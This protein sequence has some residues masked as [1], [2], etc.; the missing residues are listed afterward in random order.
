MKKLL[1]F[2]ARAIDGGIEKI[3]T[4]LCS[5]TGVESEMKHNSNRIELSEFLT[6][7][8]LK[9]KKVV[10]SCINEKQLECAELY[11][12]TGLNSLVRN[13]GSM[14]VNNYVNTLLIPKRI[15][16]EEKSELPTHSKADG[17][18]FGGHRLT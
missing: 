13:S 11:I 2:G 16:L 6:R 18:G 4:L 12:R 10:D 17:M 1:N 15:E 8:S 7:Y 14:L 5:L 3:D 9:L